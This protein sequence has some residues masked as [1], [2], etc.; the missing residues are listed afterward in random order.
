MADGGPSR[1]SAARHSSR[2]LEVDIVRHAEAWRDALTNIA[3]KRAAL[4]AFLIA[5][6]SM[7]GTYEVTILLTDD[8][9]MRTL[10]RAWR[11]KDAPT[12]VL[13][14]P[15][16]DTP[17][18]PGALGDVVLGYETIRDEGCSTNTAFTDHVS[19]L[20]IHGLLHLLGFDHMNEDEAARME[21]LE[22]DAL[23]SIGVADP[24]VEKEATPAEV[25]S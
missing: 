4:A 24:Y 13:S 23:A 15:S 16:S 3:L 1:K 7:P 17:P 11:G 2:R 22:R 19:H 20:V 8:A 5:P 10:N 9:E 14:F 21:A 18:V 25:S 6:P 12:N